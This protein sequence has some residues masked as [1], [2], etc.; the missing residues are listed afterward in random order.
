MSSRRYWILSLLD[1]GGVSTADMR[2]GRA[3]ALQVFSE[4]F[5][6]LRRSIGSPI[7]CCAVLAPGR[8]ENIHH[9]GTEDH[10]EKHHVRGPEIPYSINLSGFPCESYVKSSRHFLFFEQ[11][12][13]GIYGASAPPFKDESRPTVREAPWSA[14]AGRGRDT[15]CPAPP[16]PIQTRQTT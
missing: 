5:R 10:R 6:N 11:A 14:A 7:Y 1:A 13:W 2:A 15:G 12:S 4:F 16:A 9:R 8:E 3:N